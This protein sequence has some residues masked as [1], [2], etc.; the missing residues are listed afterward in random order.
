MVE[1]GISDVWLSHKVPNLPQAKNLFEMGL[2]ILYNFPY[3][4][5]CHGCKK[6]IGT[7]RIFNYLNPHPDECFWSCNECYQE[8]LKSP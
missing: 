5:I 7:L 2:A 3:I 6:S 1:S 8:L 4:D